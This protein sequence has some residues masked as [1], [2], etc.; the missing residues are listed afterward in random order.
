MLEEVDFTRL[1]KLNLDAPEGE[2][3]EVAAFF[4]ESSLMTGSWDVVTL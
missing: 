3:L 1:S 4:S 2:D